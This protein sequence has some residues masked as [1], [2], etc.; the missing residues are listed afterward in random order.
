MFNTISMNGFSAAHSIRPPPNGISAALQ[1][2]LYRAIALKSF[3]FLMLGGL[4]L[5]LAGQAAMAFILAGMRGDGVLNGSSLDIATLI[6][7]KGP[8]L[9]LTAALLATLLVGQ[10]YRY[11]SRTYAVTLAGSR[12]RFVAAKLLGVGICAAMVAL[13]GILGCTVIATNSLLMESSEITMG[14]IFLLT[15]RFFS[16]LGWSLIA[17]YLVLITHS[18]ILAVALLLAVPFV[19]EGSLKAAGSYLGGIAADVS[20]FF[21]FAALEAITPSGDSAMFTT[22]GL[23]PI[24]AA[25]IALVYMA[26]AAL[27]AIRRA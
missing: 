25:G 9:P 22:P 1:F 20:H 17:T 15:G 24:M 23:P 12:G 16:V 4:T 8:I 11:G 14:F 7:G 19:V 5:H 13:L 27:L 21:P 10:E 3:W 26:I 18:Q 6:V 2:E